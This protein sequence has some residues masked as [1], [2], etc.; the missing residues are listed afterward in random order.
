MSVIGD[1]SLCRDMPLSKLSVMISVSIKSWLCLK[2]QW[3]QQ[4]FRSHLSVWFLRNCKLLIGNWQDWHPSLQRRGILTVKDSHYEDVSLLS[5]GKCHC[6][7]FVWAVNG[8]NSHCEDV[9][10]QSWRQQSFWRHIFSQ[11]RQ[12]SLCC[13]IDVILMAV[14]P[15]T[16]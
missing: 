3:R 13:L 7:D 15:F 10:Y 1:I 16:V 9:F 14:Y 11:W 5:S 4:S 6:K 8:D 2:C 12:Q